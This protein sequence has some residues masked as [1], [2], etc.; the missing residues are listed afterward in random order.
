VLHEFSSI[1]GVREDVTDIVLNIKDISIKMQSDGPKRMILKKQYQPAPDGLGEMAL[2]RRSEEQDV[3]ALCDE[4]DRG[5][6][7]DEG[8]IHL[9]VEVEVEAVER[10]IGVAEPPRSECD[11]RP[12]EVFA[13]QI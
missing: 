11:R 2:A 4:A 7:V 8:A 10:A 6:L 12:P 13:R 3:V 9:L 1:P 5:E